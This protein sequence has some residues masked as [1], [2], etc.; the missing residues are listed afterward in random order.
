MELR[1][2]RYF[3]AVADHGSVRAAADFLGVRQPSVSHQIRKLEKR[4]NINLFER[5]PRGMKLTQAGSK[6]LH[7]ARYIVRDVD[8]ALHDAGRASEVKVGALSLGFYTSLCS[9]PLRE[10]LAEFRAYSPEV[11]LELHEGSPPDLLNALRDRRIDLALT[12]LEVSAR[13][14]E[15]QW[16]WDEHLVVAVPTGHEIAQREALTW[17]E[18]ATLPLV[19]R[20]WSTGSL[21]YNFLSGRIAANAYLPADQH[22]V[23]R[24][25][26]MGLVG[27][28]AGVTVLGASGAQASYDVA[29][30]NV[31]GLNW[32]PSEGDGDEEEP[33]QRR[34]D[35][36]GP[37]GACRGDRCVGAVP[38]AR[39][40]R[41]DVLHVA[42]AL[43]R[44]GSV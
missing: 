15:T 4:V 12:V 28:G 25:A 14:F 29:P 31:L 27:I 38:Q 19:V 40:Q 44:N 8:R 9:G 20:T 37:E 34:A 26:L 13:E 18:I 7:S 41:R 23:S 16:L 3:V 2:L 21:V 35:H 36:R 43:R 22:F 33:L 1:Q 5:I 32:T 30:W 6:L 17:A 24:E 39:D 11:R 10:T 42:Q